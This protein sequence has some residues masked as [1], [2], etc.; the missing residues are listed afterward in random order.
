MKQCRLTGCCFC[1]SPFMSSWAL[2]TSNLRARRKRRSRESGLSLK[3]CCTS[4]AKSSPSAALSFITARRPFSDEARLSS[5]SFS[6]SFACTT[7][8]KTLFKLTYL[9]E[10]NDYHCSSTLIRT[11]LI[12]FTFCTVWPGSLWHGPNTGPWS[13]TV[14]RSNFDLIAC[15]SSE[16]RR[17]VPVCRNMNK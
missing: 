3:R 8:T 17:K 12:R 1:R 2:I 11:I 15:S 6:S 7:Q 4:L 5:V 14:R 13:F 9:L 16:T 10:G